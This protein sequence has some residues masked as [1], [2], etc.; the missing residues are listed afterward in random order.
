M[1]EWWLG[2][3]GRGMTGYVMRGIPVLVMVLAL[4]TYREACGIGDM[5]GEEAS[6]QRFMV[7]V[8]YLALLW[9][10]VRA[11]LFCFRH[12]RHWVRWGFLLGNAFALLVI[13]AYGLGSAR[14]WDSTIHYKWV[15]YFYALMRTLVAFAFLGAQVWWCMRLGRWIGCLSADDEDGE[16]A[17]AL[18]GQDE[19]EVDVSY[20]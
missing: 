20:G 10:G 5:F 4:M 15:G 1:L 13:F 8:M 3:R 12:N 14:L 19:E 17:D 18:G 9:W 7:R 16:G 2:T 11:A 6:R